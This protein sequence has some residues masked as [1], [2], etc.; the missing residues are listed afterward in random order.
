MS[1]SLIGSGG[2]N[3][4]AGRAGNKIPRGMR[5]GQLQNFTPAQMN[6]FKQMFQQVDPESFTSQL[7]GLKIQSL[8]ICCGRCS[9]F[10][11]KN[12]IPYN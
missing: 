3:G 5:M 12:K 1:S 10:I 11:E 7:A 2:M 6:L 8:S 4:P 9:P